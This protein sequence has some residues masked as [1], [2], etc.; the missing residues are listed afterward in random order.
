MA[1]MADIAYDA[2]IDALQF[3]RMQSIRYGVM[4]GVLFGSR[5]AAHRKFLSV[6]I[7][8]YKIKI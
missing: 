1:D 5:A 2:E 4:L 8:K 7:L 3:K 6:C